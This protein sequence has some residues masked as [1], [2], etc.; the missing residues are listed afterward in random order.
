MPTQLIL[1]PY[2]IPHPTA[3][4]TINSRVE[5]AASLMQI[6][7]SSVQPPQASP[8]EIRAQEA[9]AAFTIQQALATAAALYLC[10]SPSPSSFLLEPGSNTLRK[11]TAPFVIDAVRKIF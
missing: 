3:Y 10:W 1:S 5:E 9:E 2:P 6:F 7:L 11:T 4:T 8:E